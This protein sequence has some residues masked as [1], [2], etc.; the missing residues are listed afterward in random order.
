MSPRLMLEE[1]TSACSESTRV[2]S[3]SDDISSEKKA[4][5]PPAGHQR[6]RRP[7]CRVVGACD[8]ECY[9]GGE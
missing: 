9:V 1:E 4:T 5:M 7:L 6:S 2:A 3:C 8:V